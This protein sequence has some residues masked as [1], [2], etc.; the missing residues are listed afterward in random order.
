VPLRRL[1][2]PLA[3]VLVA[4]TGCT[5]TVSGHPEPPAGSGTAPSSAPQA[6]RI[7]FRDCT[8][9]LI[10]AGIPVPGALK[11]R[12]QI[13]CGQ[14][15]VPVDYADPGKGRMPL[16]VVRIHDTDDTRPISDLQFNPGGPG[17]S[18]VNSI[19]G[20]LGQVPLTIV[21][22]FDL[23]AMDP[24]GVGLSA[25]IQCLS[26]EEKDQFLAE[27]P[28]DVTTSRGLA[29]A[30]RE[31]AQLAAACARASAGTLRYITTEN[32]ARDMDQMRQGLG[33]P[34]MSYLGFSYGTE[35]GWVY[36]DL[37]PDKV[38]AVVLDGAVDPDTSGIRQDAEQLQ[39]FEDAF[40]QFAQN[41]R[42]VSPCNQ[43][44]DP[45]ADAL[46]IA[47]AARDHPLSTGTGRPLTQGLAFTGILS[48]LYSKSAWP[49]LA[50]ALI[51]ARGGDG[52]G[53]LRL[54][55][56]YNERAPNGRYTNSLDANIAYNCNDTSAKQPSDSTIRST[57]AQ[58]ARRFPLFGAESATELV[59][60]YKWQ[61]HRTVPPRPHAATANKV[62]VVGNLHDP[63]TPY[64]GAQDLARE[65]GNAE[66]LSWNGQGHTSYLEGSSC[67][68]NY[69]NR[70]LL[71][72]TLPPSNTTCQ[73]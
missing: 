2:T 8:S 3:A 11:G 4:A 27:N 20:L 29:R 7:D 42:T 55:D 73:K 66:L 14:L 5:A 53:L 18:A 36:A 21:R 30:K 28:P 59:G 10:A 24:R 19:F 50:K 40:D 25:P 32:A 6:A 33:D 57:A 52:S 31:S 13:G 16:F 38:R 37:F 43:L 41:C 69:V 12:L 45:R 15:S 26:D 46:Q 49:K 68:D 62:L 65:L 60:C 47:T 23:V 56:N 35:L 22:H 17:V 1:L 51:D 72:K 64:Q 71:A 63:A 70:Y 54:A 39:G 34:T 44:A 61:P 9:Q 58:W 48:A 67:I